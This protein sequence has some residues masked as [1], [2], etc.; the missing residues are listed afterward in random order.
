MK[1]NELPPP[2]KAL[3]EQRIKDEHGELSLRMDIIKNSPIDGCFTFHGSKEDDSKWGSDFWYI[4]N[5]GTWDEGILE[6]A[7]SIVGTISVEPLIFN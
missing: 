6:Y 4:V 2:L 1:L 7:R 5:D 3:A